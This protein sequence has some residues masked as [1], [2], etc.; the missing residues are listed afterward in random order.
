MANKSASKCASDDNTAP[1]TVDFAA[2]DSILEEADYISNPDLQMY[3]TAATAVVP[4]YNLKVIANLTLSTAVLAQIFSGQI[5]TWDDPRI[6]SLNPNFTA[7]RVPAGQRIEVVVRSSGSGTTGVFRQALCYFDSVFASQVGAGTDSTW[8][9]VNVTLSSRPQAYVTVTP[10]TLSYTP[11][12]IAVEYLLPVPKLKK[13]T[14]A[15]VEATQTST[16]YALLELGLTFGNNGDD[17]KHLTAVLSNA[18]GDNAW[19]IATYTYLIMRKSSPKAGATCTAVEETAKFWYWF[20]TSDL[21][22]SIV[23]YNEFTPLPDI[24]RDAVVSRFMTDITCDGQ[25][26]LSTSHSTVVSGSGVSWVASVLEQFALVYALEDSTVSISY[27]SVPLLTEATVEAQLNTDMFVASH[28]PW[29]SA[30]AHSGVKLIMAGIGVVVISQYNLTLDLPTLAAILDGNITTW[31]SPALLQLNNGIIRQ[32]DGTQVTD[33]SQRIML[34][35][36]PTFEDP[37]LADTLRTYVPSFRGA[38]MSAAR[39]FS[40]DDLLRA[41]IAATPYSLGISAMVGSFDSNLLFAR[42]V[43]TDGAVVAPTWQSVQACATA[44]VY[45]AQT[46]DYRLENSNN[47][48]C[49]PVAS[50]VYIT[51]RSSECSATADPQRTAAVYFLEWL[52]QLASLAGALQDQLV[53]PLTLLAA[54]NVTNQK[55]LDTISC[56]PRV[57]VAPSID[58]LPIVIGGCCGVL[59]LLLCLIGLWVWKSTADMRALRRQFANDNVAQE[60]AAAIASFDLEAVEWLKTLENPNRI[61]R[62]FL[63]IIYLLTEVRPFIPDQLLATL[64]RGETEILQED[65]EKMNAVVVPLARHL[66]ACTVETHESDG[67]H[68]REGNPLSRHNSDVSSS[69]KSTHSLGRPVRIPSTTSVKCLATHTR[70]VHQNPTSP[71]AGRPPASSSEWRR[72]VAVFMYVRFGFSPTLVSQT[73]MPQ[74][75]T[76]LLVDLVTIAKAHGATIDHVAYRSLA[77]HWGVAFSSAQGPLKATTAALEMAQFRHRLPGHLRD[78]M[79]LRIAVTY[80]NCDVSTASAAGH[81]FFIVAGA[82]VQTAM[83]VVVQDVLA[84]CKCE[85]LISQAVYQE[86][87]FAMDC[88]PRLWFGEVLLWEPRRPQQYTGSSEEWMYELQNIEVQQGRQFSAKLLHAVFMMARCE[89][90][91]AQVQA[92]AQRL[93]ELYATEMTVQDVAALQHLEAATT[94]EAWRLSA[95]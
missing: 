59:T 8:T 10:Y 42:M 60:C 76:A 55:A 15:V 51:A 64:Q 41:A 93:R 24:I 33:A 34:I 46:G 67:E 89:A 27:S 52:L 84:K 2:S 70:G 72:K 94:V 19:P 68:D 81:R 71:R 29:T 40:S 5:L 11:Y 85:V 43:R 32:S 47:T 45:N 14:G 28:V 53:A 74:C 91:R 13:S 22:A 1:L 79:Q 69:I 9:G 56:T 6:V 75:V 25:A 30:S 54:V 49:Y 12:D 82:E 17:S 88:M 16:T 63:Q 90:S 20:W 18:Q 38:A 83:D 3:P 37:F 62:S 95:A 58:W 35:N 48:A 23:K 78:A 31:L 50:A 73:D 66:S 26:V 77:L 87:Q 65:M 36:G 7:W 21:A 86:V 57:S 44:D 61:Q 92:E 80:G 39:R 4:V